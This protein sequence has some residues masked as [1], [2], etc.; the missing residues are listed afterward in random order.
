MESHVL[1]EVSLS[2]LDQF[3][4]ISLL[5]ISLTLDFHVHLTLHHSQPFQDK[6]ISFLL[7]LGKS[8]GS[9]EDKSM[10]K[11]ISFPGEVNLVHEGVSGN[12]VVRGRSNLSLSKTSISHLEVRIEHSVG[13]SS[14][15]DSDSLQ[16]T[17]TSELVHNQWRFNISW[18]LVRVGHKATDKVRLTRVKSLH[19]LA[20]RDQVDR[21]DSLATTSLLLLPAFLLGSLSGLSRMIQPKMNQQRHCAGGL[22]DLNN[23]VVDRILV[24]L[25]PSSD[26]VGHNTSVMRD[27]KVS[28]LVSFGLG[29]QENWQLA[30]G[31]LQ[32]LLKGLVSGLGEKRFL[33]KNGP[34]T[35]GL[36]KHDDGSCQVHTKV[37]HLPVDTFLDVL[38]LFNNKH[39]MVKELLELLIDKVD[40]NLLKSVVLKNFKTSNVK[41]STKV[42]LLQ[43]SINKCVV[44]L[45]NEPLEHTVID[46]PG[47]TSNSV[48]SL[49][50]SLTL[51][52]PLGT[53]LDPGLAES[54]DHVEGINTTESSSLAWISVRSNL[55]TLSLVITTLGLEL[56]TAKGHNSSGQ[57]VAVK[58]LLLRE[59]KNVEGIFSV[60]KLFVVINGIDLCFTLTD[61]D[62]VIDVGGAV[63]L[64][65]ETTLADSISIGLNKLVEDVVGSLNLLLLSNT[66]LLKQ[67]GDNVATSQL[68]RGSEMESA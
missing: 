49:L 24:L 56:N 20:Q 13:E 19:E 36:L 27:G 40:G 50:A 64:R 5:G 47:N 33:L 15:T 31:S 45:L 8:S 37:N 53:D 39:V 60:L 65:S 3:S 22:E 14:H 21:G 55:L 9:E 35:H 12:L 66:R 58:L 16:H 6:F 17:I 18:L 61:I 68:T 38:F 29:L 48:G 52:D 4:L 25:K 26:I 51:G 42:G 28:I 30:K 67:I 1:S 23:S 63:T 46:T 41:H 11:P 44:T 34:D 43:C 54:L 10:S 7:K 62:V 59:S 32:L 57:H 2:N